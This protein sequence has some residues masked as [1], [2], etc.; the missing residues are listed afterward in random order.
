MR[1]QY[2]VCRLPSGR[3]IFYCDPRKEQKAVPWDETDIR[4]AWSYLSFQGKSAHRKT[5][6]G[7]LL[8]EYVTQ[9]VARDIMVAGMFRCE[10]EGLPVV[11]TV[12]DELVTEPPASRN[13]VVEVL[14]G[15]M[16]ARDPWVVEWGIPVAAEC[17]V[18]SEYQK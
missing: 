7:G 15:C 1:G 10:K 5:P 6:F 4:P 13:D 16:E 18:M 9:A 3:E 14:R 17:D 2:L 12:H 11:F 8:A